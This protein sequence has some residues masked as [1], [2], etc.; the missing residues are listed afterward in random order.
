MM[1]GSNLLI[2]NPGFDTVKLKEKWNDTRAGRG[3]TGAETQ[4]GS[5]PKSV[6][7]KHCDQ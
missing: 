6:I 3:K 2:Q 4:R 5:F 1:N 7:G